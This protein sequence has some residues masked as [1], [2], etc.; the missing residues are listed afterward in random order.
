[1]TH[2]SRAATLNV[3]FPPEVRHQY[4]FHFFSSDYLEVKNGG[5][6]RNIIMAQVYLWRNLRVECYKIRDLVFTFTRQRWSSNTL[7]FEFCTIS[8]LVMP[9]YEVFVTNNFWLAHCGGEVGL[10]RVVLRLR[11]TKIVLNLG[12]KFFFKII[13]DPFL[14]FRNFDPLTVGF[15]CW[16][17]A[18][19]SQFILLSLR[20]SGIEF[21]L[22]S[23]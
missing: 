14:V 20:L 11:G 15:M 3:K 16:S 13:Y 8:L 1:M 18:K 2:L 12:Q 10:F 9:K 6:S 22:A 5:N 7:N 23:D 19:M 4:C 21:N 17:W